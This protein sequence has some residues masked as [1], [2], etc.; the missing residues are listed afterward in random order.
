M[1]P[2]VSTEAPQPRTLAL[3]PPPKGADIAVL[4]LIP[5]PGEWLAAYSVMRVGCKTGGAVI[6]DVCALSDLAGPQRKKAD[7]W[8]G[9]LGR[10]VGAS[11][12]VT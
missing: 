10:L 8:M 6:A 2:E 4:G 9:Q 7:N 3:R 1:A 5:Q 12:P 11:N